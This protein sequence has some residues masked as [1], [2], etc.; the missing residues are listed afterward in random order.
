M[1]TLAPR[2]TKK[3]KPAED[4]G[5]LLDVDKVLLMLD[6]GMT[7]LYALMKSGEL[8]YVDLGRRCR[9]FDPADVKAFIAKRKRRG[10]AS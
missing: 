4:D 6:I 8:P 7:N 9:R 5:R 2:R 10:I 3:K 1:P